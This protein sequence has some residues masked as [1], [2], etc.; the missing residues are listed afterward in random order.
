MIGD[1]FFAAL[2]VVCPMMILMVI[3]WLCR[4]KGVISRPA[5]KEYDRVIF[6]IFMPLLLFKNIYEM[7][8]SG[9]FAQ[10]E[11]M[12]AAV[13][14]LMNF[15]FCLKFPALLTDDPKKSSVIGQAVVR[16]NYIIFGV[17]VSE[18]LY[19]EGNIGM[20]VMM[21][22]LVVPVINIFSAIILEA[23]RSGKASIGKLLI[24]V[25]KNPM[26]IGAIFAFIFKGFN[27]PIPLPVWSVIRSIANATTTVSFISLGVGLDMA[28]S[29]GDRRLLYWGIFLRMAV[30]PLV[31]MPFAILAGFRG[32][33]LCAMMV[34]FA[35]PSA[36]ASYPMAVA[37]GA[38]GKLA[39]QLVCT[40]TILSVLTIFL[41]TFGLKSLGM[42]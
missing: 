27:I 18:A 30:L 2:R 3:G 9:G 28:D 5:M 13:C 39:G 4:V 14:M 40:T 20:V 37:M 8:F 26:I 15:V 33:S 16:G 32:Q 31:F 17:T 42:M 21:G 41:W 36:V 12:F 38:D 7:D 24:A 35:A 25:L 22:V 6:K 10:K 23:G 1:S 11:M 34:I 29:F 19:G